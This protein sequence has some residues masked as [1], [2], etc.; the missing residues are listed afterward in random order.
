MKVETNK[1]IETAQASGGAVASASILAA[2]FGPMNN[3]AFAALLNSFTANDTKPAVMQ[4]SDN[5]SGKM[6]STQ[7]AAH[8]ANAVPSKKESSPKAAPVSMKK[9]KAA[10]VPQG[11]ANKAN[12]ESG[13]THENDADADNAAQTDAQNATGQAAP[14]QQTQT[15][16]DQAQQPLKMADVIKSL[17]LNDQ[18]VQQLAQALN[19]SAADLKQ[20]QITVKTD[21]QSGVAQLTALMADGKQQNLSAMLGMNAADGKPAPAQTVMDKIAGILKLDNNQKKDFFTQLNISTFEVAAASASNNAGGVPAIKNAANNANDT[22]AIKNGDAAKQADQT[23]PAAKSGPSFIDI[24]K[25]AA[26]DAAQNRAQQDAGGNGGNAFNGEAG[27]QIMAAAQKNVA[28]DEQ[29]QKA[30]FSTALGKAGE[31]A[32]AAVANGTKTEAAHAAAQTQ[33]AEASKPYDKVMNQ[34]VEK[35]SILQL[36]NS[37]QTKISL[38]PKDLGA[39]DIKLVMHDATVTAS[40]VVENHA[41]KQ[42]V[43]QNLDQLKNALQQQGITVDEMQVSVDQQNGGNSQ[44]SNQAAQWEAARNTPFGGAAR[45]A[46][47][48]AASAPYMRRPLGNHR[49]S[50]TA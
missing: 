8:A 9:E 42:V 29:T 38:N 25:A 50:L 19:I 15:G 3:G 21:A 47:P 7:T 23:Q 36:P 32:G 11:A 33:A 40:I 14:A 4:P 12:S 46:E 35:A 2:T 27:A 34:I 17:N 10:D 39:V 18:Q 44:N 49:V 45:A 22:S 1:A 31:A 41:V 16:A 28:A 37:T 26:Q 48:V 43:E 24:S 30:D 6:T 13:E 5:V 20:M